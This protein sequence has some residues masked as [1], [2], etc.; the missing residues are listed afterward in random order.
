MGSPQKLIRPGDRV[1]IKPNMLS[2]KEPERAVTTHPEVIAAVGELV[3]DCGGKLIIGD[4]P[5]GAPKSLEKHWEKSGLG[6]VAHRL[7]IKPV[8]FEDA[9]LRSFKA[10]GGYISISRVAL[11]ADHII[12]LPK[13]KTHMLTGMSGAVKNMFGTVPGFRKSFLHSV[14]PEALPFSRLVLTVYQHVVPTLNVMDAVVGMEGNGP[15]SG[16]A[17]HIGAM[18]ISQDALSL[19]HLAAQIIGLEPSRLPI[20]QAAVEAGL[21]DFD[22]EPVDVLGL[23]PSELG[24][25]DFRPPDISKLERLPEFVRSGLKKV[26]WIRPKADAGICTACGLCVENCPEAAM[27]LSNDVPRIDYK[28]CIKCGCCDEICEDNAIYQELSLLARLLA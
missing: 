25:N 13:L 14:A 23:D 26:I 1:L 3:L 12:N 9:G 11:E 17:R 18:L 20:F 10:P 19:D 7:G 21:W 24:L 4:S 8:T 22:R 2:A 28:L 6:D 16:K 5:A 15:S 27:E